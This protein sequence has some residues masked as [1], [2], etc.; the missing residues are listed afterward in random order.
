MSP[1]FPATQFRH[2]WKM[3][4]KD[5]RGIC[6]K[7]KNVKNNAKKKIHDDAKEHR[8]LSTGKMLKGLQ[9]FWSQS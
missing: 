7:P 3:A 1:T 9:N 5:Y 2:F 6:G 4:L 8:A